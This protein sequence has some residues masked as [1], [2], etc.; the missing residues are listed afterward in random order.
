LSVLLVIESEKQ[1]ESE[2]IVDTIEFLCKIRPLSCPGFL[3][4]RD[5][6]INRETERDRERNRYI[7]AG[8]VNIAL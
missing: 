6:D 5:P 1:S 4:S 3:L 8:V 2:G 7:T